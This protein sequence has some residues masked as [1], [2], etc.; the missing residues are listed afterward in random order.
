MVIL[1]TMKIY[2]QKLFKYIKKG[3]ITIVYAQKTLYQL[4]KQ[5]RLKDVDLPKEDMNKKGAL[6][7]SVSNRHVEAHIYYHSKS[8]LL[9][10]QD[11]FTC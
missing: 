4:V 10:S 9:M 2:K 8:R 3:I 7:F 11:A 5:D 6:L 1:F